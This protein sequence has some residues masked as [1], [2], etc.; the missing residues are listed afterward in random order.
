LTGHATEVVVPASDDAGLIGCSYAEQ[1]RM[2]GASLTEEQQPPDPAIESGAA[3]LAALF[4]ESDTLLFRPIETWVESGKKRSRVDYRNTCYRKA[5]PALLKVTLLQLL[6]IAN[7]ERLNLFFGVCP[8][9]GNKGRFDLAWQVRTVRCLWT[10]IDHI[11]VDEAQERITKAGLPPPSIIVNSGNGVHL[12]WLLDVPYQ[13]DDAGDP[14]PVETEWLQTPDGRKKP[15]KYIVENGDK[16]YLDQR[17]HV[18]R[19]SPK[20]EHLQDVLAGIAKA[21]GGDHTTDLSRLLRIPGTFNRKDQRNGREPVPTAL[22]DFDP[23]RKYSLATF[24]RLKSPSP[25]TERAKLIAAMPLPQ[26]RK[27]SLSKAD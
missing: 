26:P 6:R 10:D 4:A 8:R 23:S 9:N 16:V 18:S 27:I 15:R 14:L 25:E 7:Q 1:C 24:E 2:D 20:A 13:V 12:Y 11:T 5:V 19:L 21:I 17:R 22:V 3:F